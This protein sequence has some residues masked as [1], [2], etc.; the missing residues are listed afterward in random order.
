MRGITVFVT[1]G[2]QTVYI[3]VIGDIVPPILVVL[4]RGRNIH[5]IFM[6]RTCKIIIIYT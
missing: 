1:T 3:V 5:P 6:N 4:F 2:A